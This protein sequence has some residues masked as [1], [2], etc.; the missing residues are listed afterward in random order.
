MTET[1]RAI[2]QLIEIMARLRAPDGC[3]WD[4]KQTL[5]TIAPYTIEEA[6]EVVEAI[7]MEDMPALKEELGDLLF[8]VVFYAQIAK[9]KS[10]FDFDQIAQTI[11][12][13][14][15]R[16]HPHVFADVEY[17]SETEQHAAW[18]AIKKQEKPRSDD[19]S[20]LA[21]VDVG[22]PE[23]IRAEKLQKK[24]AKT[25]FDWPQAEAVLD[26]VEEEIA[27]LKAEMNAQSSQAKL[28]DEL[29]DVL[30]SCIN[31]ARHLKIDSGQALRQANRKFESRFRKMEQ[32]GD[33]AALSPEQME[34]LWAEVKQFEE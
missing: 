33:L 27:E 8:Q 34:A 16:R 25:G 1:G 29:G 18:D 24:A 28:E 31:L 17:Q 9:E 23:L 19:H 11:S 13:K 15:I 32:L 10:L 30:F 26:K 22:L 6:Y 14:M 21:G 5:K 7:E 2:D 4:R 12:E 3:A 20:A